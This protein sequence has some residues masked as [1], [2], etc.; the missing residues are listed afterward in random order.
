MA[1]G[2]VK[3]FNGEKGFGFITPDEGGA[4]VFVHY[5]EIDASGFR[6]LDEG[7]QVTTPPTYGQLGANKP[8]RIDNASMPFLGLQQVDRSRLAILSNAQF[9][10]E[11]SE[12]DDAGTYFDLG[13]RQVTRNG[14]YNYLCTRNNNFSN[15]NQ[16]ARITVSDSRLKS[17]S[18]NQ[19][20]GSVNAGNARLYASG[21]ALTG[22]THISILSTSKDAKSSISGA[23]ASEYIEVQPLMLTSL[24]AG[25]T[26]TL[27]I[28][29]DKNPIGVSSMYR[30]DSMFG[31]WATQDSDFQS[32][33][34][35]TKINK[36]GVYVIQAP[37]NW[38]AVAGVTL[39]VL[40]VI[41]G[42]IFYGYRKYRMPSTAGVEKGRP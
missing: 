18:L 36:G 15:R 41:F 17:A 10:G 29:Y 31:S 8:A 4:D 27:Q 39:A 2:I 33:T 7:Q 34:G 3:W 32:G 13:P 21:T 23:V 42:C 35:S 28:D 38:G 9:G 25:Q 11:M 30:S 22:L 6:S 20:G 37:T 14:I 12:L 1:Q 40:A 24:A 26:L 19:A 16:A 5:S